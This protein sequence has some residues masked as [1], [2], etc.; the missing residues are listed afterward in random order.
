MSSR[1]SARIARRAARSAVPFGA[2]IVLAT[3]TSTLLAQVKGPELLVPKWKAVPY[4]LTLIT[5]SQANFDSVLESNFPGI[6]DGVSD[7]QATRPYLVM[8]R[9]NAPLASI[10]Y[11]IEWKVSYQD[12]KSQTWSSTS[13][14]SPLTDL[15]S[16]TLT[17]GG[18]RL[19]SPSFNLTPSQYRPGSLTG[20]LSQA[21]L[22]SPPPAGIA[23][24]V[25]EV[26]G[27]V[28]GGGGY[29]GPEGAQL[30]RRWVVTRFAAVD[31]ARYVLKALDSSTPL[32]KIYS[33][34]DQQYLR[35]QQYMG[36]TTMETYINARGRCAA[37]AEWLLQNAGRKAA[38]SHF[39]NT[40]GGS[41]ASSEGPTVFGT[42]YERLFDTSSSASPSDGK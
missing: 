30:W 6:L 32:P 9:N 26:I 19:V 8:I 31:V 1:G 23:S 42:A 3:V 5:P 16:A 14:L 41:A 2:L 10:A 15:A 7:F 11:V 40:A 27:V 28:W 21:S 37:R 25:P 4:S 35:G 20:W 36:T 39:L 12:G 17:P 24:S 29:S 22:V 13:I 18:I 38:V 33:N 34:L